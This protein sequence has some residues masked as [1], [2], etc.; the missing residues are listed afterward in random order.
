LIRR[1]RNVARRQGRPAAAAA[2]SV[3]CDY[4]QC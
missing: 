3:R 1:G 4:A 2:V